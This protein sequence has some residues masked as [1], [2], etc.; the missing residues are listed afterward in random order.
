LFFC[1]FLERLAGC[2][3]RGISFSRALALARSY[4]RHS[5][6]F[7]FTPIAE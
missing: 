6:I 2:N 5:S 4:P 3:S 7:F 1:H